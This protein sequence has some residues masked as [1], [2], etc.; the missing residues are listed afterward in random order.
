MIN[1]IEAIVEPLSR[2]TEQ[3]FKPLRLREWD[4]LEISLD[5]EARRFVVESKS[6]REVKPGQCKYCHD[7]E[8]AHTVNH[9]PFTPVGISFEQGGVSFAESGMPMSLDATNWVRRVPEQRDNKNGKFTLAGTDFT[10][11]L[12][13]HL[14]PKNRVR[15]KT[16]DAHLMYQY[17]YQR[18]VSQNKAAMIAAEFKVNRTIP[19]L[20]ADFIDHPTY[21][22][23]PFQRV[24]VAM[25]SF[26]EAAALFMQQGT[27]KT[28]TSIARIMLEAGRKY[29]GTIPGV[30]AGMYRGIIICPNAVRYNW[31]LEFEKFATLPGKVTVLRGGQLGRGRK[32]TD[33]VRTEPD[34][35]WSMVIIGYD[36]IESVVDMLKL[37]PWDIAIADE[38]HY[39]KSPRTRRFKMLK[40][41]R[42][43]GN[44]RQRMVLTGT[45]IAN[46]PMDLWSQLEFLG[47]GISGFMSFSQFKAFH[48]KWERGGGGGG[49]SIEKLVGLQ[50]IPLLQERLARISFTITKEDAGLDLPDKVPLVIEIEMTK[51]QAEWYAKVRDQLVLEIEAEKAEAEQQGKR[52]RADHILTKLLRLAQITSGFIRWDDQYDENGVLLREGFAEPIPGENP[53]LEAMIERILAED[54][55]PKG[56]TIIWSCFRASINMI[57]DR[58]EEEGIGF[59]EYYGATSERDREIAVR[60]FNT[61][62]TVKVFL[63]NP[64]TAGAGLNLLGYDPSDPDLV[65]TYT[66]EE[67][68]FDQGW[69]AVLRSQAEDRAHRKGTKTNVTIADFVVPGTIDD[70]IRKRVTC[71]IDTAN[72]IQDLSELM[73]DVLNYDISLLEK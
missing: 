46:T 2:A 19:K 59:V 14:W 24:P 68:F 66:N 26:K 30:K 55:D 52:L 37:V 4:W 47:D 34:C 11:L 40:L 63:A 69:S 25:F 65:D 8:Q 13:E 15:F 27:G 48:G 23:L 45:P 41:L 16:S 72:R 44:I 49:S 60:R 17:L 21:P 39:I 1:T 22:P 57:S 31:Q 28:S 3:V 53:K 7:V 51:Q 33:A 54:A 43:E 12:I 5:D 20:P 64:A 32:L 18:F 10:V 67:H 61:D 71:K 35:I 56:K 29:Q 42:D 50:N 62:P 6:Y 9:H 36:S 58:L 73:R 70:E 38:S